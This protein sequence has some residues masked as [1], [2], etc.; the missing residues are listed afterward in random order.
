[1]WFFCCRPAKRGGLRGSWG[2]LP[3]ERL[4]C[5]QEWEGSQ[6]QHPCP[7]PVDLVLS[8]SRG[9]QRWGEG[10]ALLFPQGVQIW[11]PPVSQ[12]NRVGNWGWH[13]EGGS[14]LIANISAGLRIFLVQWFQPEPFE[15]AGKVKGN[16]QCPQAHQKPSYLLSI[17]QPREL[18]STYG[19]RGWRNERTSPI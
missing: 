2:Q 12:A 9:Q 14:E 6:P 18:K 5:G 19:G 3:P 7:I 8:C 17:N 1:M 16:C 11:L 15:V 10:A 4:P 13:Q